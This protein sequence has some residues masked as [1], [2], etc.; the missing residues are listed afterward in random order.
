MQEQQVLDVL[1][2][3]ILQRNDTVLVDATPC[4][5]PRKQRSRDAVA[6]ALPDALDTCVWRSLAWST[7]ATMLIW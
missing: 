7:W 1:C 4:L 5:R 3:A 6:F 2:Q